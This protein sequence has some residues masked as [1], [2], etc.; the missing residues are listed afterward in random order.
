[1]STTQDTTTL[2]ERI[3]SALRAQAVSDRPVGDEDNDRLLEVFVN[4]AVAGVMTAVSSAAAARDILIHDLSIVLAGALHPSAELG[5]APHLAAQRLY[6]GLGLADG[7]RASDVEARLRE[8][9][10]SEEEG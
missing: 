2:R 4:D 1:M 8:L 5:P 9:L 10:G 6:E 3:R 7:P